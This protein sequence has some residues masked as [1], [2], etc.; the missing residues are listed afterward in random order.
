MEVNIAGYFNACASV[1]EQLDQAQNRFV[2]ELV[3]SA[4]EAFLALNFAHSKLI[5]KVAILGLLRKR[6]IGKCHPAFELFLF[7][8]S[9]PF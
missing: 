5:R 1:L 6:V 2:C 3:L 9:Q 4:A 7:W 8:Y